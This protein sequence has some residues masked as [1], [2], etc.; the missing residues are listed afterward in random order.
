VYAD[1]VA[2]YIRL[3]KPGVMLIGATSLGR[4]L[5]PRLSTRFRTGLTADCTRLEMKENTDLV[6]IRPAFGGNIM[7]QIVTENTRPQF[8]TVR[9]KVMDAPV[10]SAQPSGE[11]LRRSLP[12]DARMSRVSLVKVS[13]LP[14]S[15]SISDS[16]ILVVG[17]RALKKEGDLLMIQRLAG[18]LRGDWAVSRPLAEKGWA[19]SERQIGLSGRTVRPKL[20][21][22]CGVSGAIQFTACMNASEKIVA[23]NTD[24]NAPIFEVAHL[25]V[26]GDLYQVLPEL[27][28]RLTEDKEVLHASV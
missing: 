26:V 18:L 22:A 27:I 23:I 7:A 16:E 12:E 6:Q 9:Y 10:R 19:P 4:S 13:P 28:N 17:G 24:P 20:L 1:C 25:A 5:A 21:I 14:A 11:I 2:D 8:A 3:M 15:K